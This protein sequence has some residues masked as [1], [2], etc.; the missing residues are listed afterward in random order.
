M[1]ETAYL[2]SATA[3]IWVALYYLP[4]GGAIFRLVLPLPLALLQIR[5]RS[6]IGLEG[7]FLT[8]LLLVALM[9]P[10]RGPLILFPYGILAVWLGW[11]WS[12]CSSW[13]FSWF[14]G[15]FIGVGGFFVRVF[16]LSLLVG[17]NLWVIITRAGAGL[18]ERFIDLFNLQLVPD[19]NQVQIASI[20]L[21][22][23]QEIIYVL[24]LHAVAFWLFPR[25][26]G[27][28][29]S[30]PDLLNRLIVIDPL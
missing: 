7:L 11:C 25:L 24:T 26:G 20:F 30:P 9:G 16:A 8:V 22:L 17:E 1:T 5:R 13:W 3:L 18:L 21:V 10:V 14:S 19:L 6:S 15:V 27:R 2:A 12:R 23:L 4:V 29:P 28:M